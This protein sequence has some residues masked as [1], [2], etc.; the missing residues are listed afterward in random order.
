MTAIAAS[1]PT[2]KTAIFPG[3]VHTWVEQAG[4]ICYRPSRCGKEVDVLLVTSCRNGAW[5]IP[6]GHVERGETTYAAAAREA[7]EEAGVSG[8]V[9]TDVAGSYAYRKDGCASMYRVDV[10]LVAVEK[11]AL[12]YPE[13]HLRGARWVPASVAADGV[14]QPELRAILG[15]IFT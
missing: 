3:H 9:R 12:E 6:K 14:R 8:I 5:G 11:T 15:S 4:A 10:H 2:A 1:E 13:K 7:F